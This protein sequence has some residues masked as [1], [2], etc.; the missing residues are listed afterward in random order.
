[1]LN[2]NTYVVVVDTDS[3]NRSPTNTGASAPLVC[4]GF[5]GNGK[6][7]FALARSAGSTTKYQVSAGAW[8]GSWTPLS[9]AALDNGSN[10]VEFQLQ[11]SDLGLAPTN[12]SVGLY[13]YVCNGTSLVSAWPPENVQAGT[14]PTL[15][16][17]V[18]FS[19]NDT[20]RIPRTY[21]RH[22]G[23]E[24]VTVSTGGPFNLLN[25]YVRLSNVSGV[26]G[27]AFTASVNGNADT[28]DPN[29]IRR[30]YT[31]T[32]GAGCTG[33]TAD[34]T[35]KYEDGTLANNAPDELAGFMESSLKLLRWS[36]SSW[37]PLPTTV[38]T[39]NNAATTAAVNQFS[40]WSLGKGSPTAVTISSFTAVPLSKGEAGSQFVLGLGLVELLAGG[41][42][43]GARRRVRQ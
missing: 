13:L 22:V 3:T 43:F 36:G 15:N 35:L 17:E 19:T 5:N 1:A 39:V 14:N 26:S 33:L 6:G 2:T 27:C 9:T 28:A 16:T 31:L 34:L 4:A 12:S 42:A 24:Q 23:D 10:N 8:A 20:G 30:T 40:P 38:D 18:V 32:P 7:D 21:G 29:T 37:S 41:I 11:W 25:G